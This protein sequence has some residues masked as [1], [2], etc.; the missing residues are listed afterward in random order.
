[1]LC[2]SVGKEKGNALLCEWMETKDTIKQLLK[3][4]GKWKLKSIS[5]F[6]LKGCIFQGPV[7]GL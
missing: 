3:V 7:S 4:V 6:H 1:M 2:H 5:H